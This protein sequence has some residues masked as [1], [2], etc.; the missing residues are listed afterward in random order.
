MNP[1]SD[2]DPVLQIIREEYPKLSEI[3]YLDHAG[4]SLYAKSQLEGVHKELSENLL[5]N[6]HT[7]FGNVEVGYFTS[8][9][10]CPFKLFWTN[11]YAF[12]HP[13]T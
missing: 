12:Y 4:S 10:T 2:S 3:T 11:I 8:I 13:P 1:L 7:N 9:F 6:P 5:C